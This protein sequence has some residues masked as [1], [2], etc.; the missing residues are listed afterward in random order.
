VDEAKLDVL[1]RAGLTAPLR[2]DERRELLARCREAVLRNGQVLCHEGQPGHSMYLLLSG[3]VSILRGGTQIAVGRPGDCLGE[4][5]LIESRERIATI[6]ALEASLALEIP[7]VVFREQLA[8]N[9]KTLLA[10]LRV[11][12]ERSRRG[13]ESLASDNVK[14]QAYATEVERSNQALSEIRRQLEEKN[15]LLERLSALDTLT[16]IANRRRFDAVLRH[17]WR[18]A[19]RDRAPLSLVFC[20]IDDFKRFNDTYGHPAGDHC[21]VRVA[22][23]MELLLNR[24]ADLAARYGGE[25]FVALLVDTGPDGARTLAERMRRRVE[26]LRLEHRASSVAPHLTVSLGVATV[27]PRRSLRPESLLEQADRALYSAKHLGRNCVVSADDQP[28]PPGADQ[29]Y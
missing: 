7:E 20:D 16:G 5:A 21:L 3:R 25:E 6:R 14:L 13:L 28:D 23:S 18:R 22:H 12:S 17:E 2:E 4:M 29:R 26:E 27:V 1:R 10:L 15:R 9:P 19:A 11:F 24:P 8:A